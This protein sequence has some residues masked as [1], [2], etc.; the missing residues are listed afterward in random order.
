MTFELWVNFESWVTFELGEGGWDKQTDTHT[1]THTHTHTHQYHDSAWPGAGPREKL[2]WEQ[3]NICNFSS[4]S[5]DDTLRDQLDNWSLEKKFNSTLLQ[6][7]GSDRRKETHIAYYLFDGQTLM[8]EYT[9]SL[10]PKET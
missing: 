8:P 3:C 4:K 1:D 6:L 9:V 5:V 2:I 7:Q 10:P